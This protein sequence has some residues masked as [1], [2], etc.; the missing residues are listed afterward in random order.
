MLLIINISCFAQASPWFLSFSAGPVIGGPSASLKSQMRAQG[1]DDDAVSTFVIFGS[2]T[3][4][5][6]HGGAGAFLMRAG[7]RISDYRSLYLVT[8]ISQ[9]ATVEGFRAQGWSDG[10]FG[11]FAGTYG[12]KVSVSYSVYELTAGYQY[13]FS[14]T[15]SKI[16]FGPSAFLLRYSNDHH[17]GHRSSLVPGVSFTARVPFGRERRSLGFELVFETR[18]A[19]PVKMKFDHTEGFEPGSV[20]MIHGSAGLAFAFRKKQ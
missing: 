18:L 11:L 15:R 16:G 13:S 12:Q 10:I 20:N 9:K 3:T 2:G 6:P 4:H 17:A 14:N 1:F 19:P 5:Y 8:G 7:K